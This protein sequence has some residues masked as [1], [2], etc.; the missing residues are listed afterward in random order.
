MNLSEQAKKLLKKLN[1]YEDETIDELFESACSSYLRGDL[2]ERLNYYIKNKYLI[3][4]SPMLSNSKKKLIKAKDLFLFHVMLILLMTLRLHGRDTIRMNN[5]LNHG[6]DLTDKFMNA[7]END[8]LW[9]LI[10]PHT[11]LVK[12]SMKS[13]QIWGEILTVSSKTGEPYLNF[14]DTITDQ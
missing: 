5:S 12:K 3:F 8:E 2:E 4:S 1:L 13:R 7:V 10:D 6:I 14:I 11:K 9:D